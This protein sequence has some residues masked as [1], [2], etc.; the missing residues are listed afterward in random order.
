LPLQRAAATGEEIHEEALTL[1]FADDDHLH[2]VV[3]A[4]PLHDEAGEIIGAVAGFVE[5]AV[6]TAGAPVHGHANDMCTDRQT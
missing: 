2:L 4:L 5:T 3:N 1:R 6:S